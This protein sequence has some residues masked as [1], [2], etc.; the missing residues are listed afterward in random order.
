MAPSRGKEEDPSSGESGGGAG[1]AKENRKNSLSRLRAARSSLDLSSLGFG[2]ISRAGSKAGL[3]ELKEEGGVSEGGSG[4]EGGAGRG[5]GAGRDRLWLAR[6]QFWKGQ[7]RDL[8][9]DDMFHKE[10]CINIVGAKFLKI[11]FINR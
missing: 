9:T 4:S 8:P 2:S 5:G 3:S 7:T 11:A 1:T 6:T 10:S